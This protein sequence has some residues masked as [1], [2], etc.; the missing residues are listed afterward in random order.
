MNNSSAFHNREGMAKKHKS[1]KYPLKQ[2]ILFYI[3]LLA[4]NFMAINW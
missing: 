3:I 2:R 4:S 1:K